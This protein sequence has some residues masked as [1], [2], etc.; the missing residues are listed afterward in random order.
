M[1]KPRRLTLAMV[2]TVLKAQTHPI[3]THELARLLGCSPVTLENNLYRWVQQAAGVRSVRKGPREF[4]GWS[5]MPPEECPGYEPATP[6][7]EDLMA[8]IAVLRAEVKQLRAGSRREESVP[9]ETSAAGEFAEDA[10]AV[11]VPGGS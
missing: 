5:Y 11:G 7:V 4:L 3:P 9:V 1:L 8:E 2:R 6:T 10:G